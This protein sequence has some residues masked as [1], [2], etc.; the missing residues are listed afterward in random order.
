MFE[1]DQLVTALESLDPRDR[2]LLEFSLRRRVPDEDLARVYETDAA[3]LARRRAAAVDRLADALEIKR[4]EDLGTMLKA[5]LEPGTWETL[6][7]PEP[8]VEEP[9]PTPAE[10]RQPVLE[11]LDEGERHRQRQGPGRRI[12]AVL[13]GAILL[14]GGGVAAGAVALGGDDDREPANAGPRPFVPQA[15]GPVA[16]PFA[17][18]TKDVSGYLTATIARATKIYDRPDG[19]PKMTLSP[20]TE[21]KS[22]RVFGVTEERGGW[23]A[24]QAPEL[25]NGQTAWIRS[26]QAKLGSVDYSLHADLSRRVL[27]VRRGGREVKRMK[28]AIGSRVHPTPQGRFSVTDKLRVEQAGSPYGCCVL[29]LSGHQTR[30]PQDWPGGDRLAVHATT[31]TRSIGERV[32]LGCMR[33]T[34]GQARWLIDTVPIGAPIFIRS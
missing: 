33:A 3:D 8:A 26:S 24:I 2:E 9:K 19:T 12:A 15:G 16:A 4:G 18:S 27:V 32:S 17:S 28:V 21:W 6:D 30:L 11:I 23:L 20:K 1:R 10:P 14:V 31:D 29:A 25:D 5:L 13:A 7:P 34:S 22:P